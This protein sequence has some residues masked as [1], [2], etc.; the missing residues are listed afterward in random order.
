MTEHRHEL[1]TLFSQYAKYKALAC[2]QVYEDLDAWAKRQSN[3]ESEWKG[4]YGSS[5]ELIDTST[6]LS[7]MVSS[8]GA[9]A[10]RSRKSEAR[11]LKSARVWLREFL[12]NVQR[13]QEMRQNHVHVWNEKK[14]CKVPLTH[15]QCPDDPMKCKAGFPR[16][17]WKVNKTLLLCK[18]F[19]KKRK[20]ALYREKE[21][22]WIR[23]WTF[24]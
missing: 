16:T 22:D 12:K 10:S 17:T 13:R 4:Q 14:N 23:T 5:V 8:I 11:L 1:E 21:F 9:Q 18:G 20:N 24:E 3:T 2:R 19:L 6:Y 7:K 15:C